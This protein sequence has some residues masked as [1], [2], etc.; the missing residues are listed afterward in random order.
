MYQDNLWDTAYRIWT[1]LSITH[2]MYDVSGW[3]RFWVEQYALR[4]SLIMATAYGDITV[5]T[6]AFDNVAALDA[7]VSMPLRRTIGGVV[8]ILILLESPHWM[9]FG[10][11]NGEHRDKNSEN[12]WS[13]GF[14]QSTTWRLR[15]RIQVILLQ[16]NGMSNILS[17]SELRAAKRNCK[18]DE[19]NWNVLVELEGLYS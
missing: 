15:I 3:Q 19:L 17:M 16:A 10:V 12:N 9:C 11:C 14:K 1:V 18:S 7:W 6:A 2:G 4:T 8:T 5:G 13:H